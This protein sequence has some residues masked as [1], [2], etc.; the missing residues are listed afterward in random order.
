MVDTEHAAGFGQISTR[1]L[2]IEGGN[3]G[4]RVVCVL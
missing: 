2:F 4:A 1:S 3:N